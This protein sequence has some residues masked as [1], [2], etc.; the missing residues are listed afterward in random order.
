MNKQLWNLYKN[1]RKR[2]E[3]A[4]NTFN[5]ERDWN[6][7]SADIIELSNKTDNALQGLEPLLFLLYANTRE[8]FAART[9]SRNFPR[10]H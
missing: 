7:C 1:D 6:E 3:Q 10:I 8:K 5:I 4:V 2:Y 9:E